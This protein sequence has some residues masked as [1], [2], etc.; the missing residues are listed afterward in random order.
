MDYGAQSYLNHQVEG[1]SPGRLIDL[2]F[3]RAR[4]DLATAAEGLEHADACRVA[5][6]V[7]SVVHA[8]QIVVELRA[9]LNL[10][11]GGEL[12]R[13]LKDLYEYMLMRLQEAAVERR[14]SAAT[15]TAALLA[16][17]HEAWKLAV[18]SVP[19]AVPAEAAQRLDALVA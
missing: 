13:N 18:L 17:L 4:R 16:E 14:S 15:E 10:K 8:Q 2:L 7:R 9:S 6:A 3:D 5:E 19:A 12:A 11:A 1:V